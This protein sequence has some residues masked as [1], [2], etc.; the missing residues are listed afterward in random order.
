MPTTLDCKI[1]GNVFGTPRMREVF[2]SASLFQ[3]WL[4]AWAALAEAQADV[5]VIPK[6]AAQQIRKVA[7]ADNFDLDEI[8]RGIDEGRHIL[9]PAIR[10][11]VKAAGDAGKYVHWGATTN[12]ITD[13]GLVLQIRNALALIG[14]ELD[15]IIDILI[16]LAKRHRSDVMA[17][18]T[19]WQHALLML[20]LFSFCRL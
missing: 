7:R 10:A 4:D 9:M 14:P 12:D 1:M 11:L 6:D 5:G 20:F 19:H 15:A 17:A 18:R 8:S 3:G 13:T 2:S 16:A